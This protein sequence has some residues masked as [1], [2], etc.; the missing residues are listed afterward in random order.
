MK[1]SSNIL[2]LRFLIAMLLCLLNIQGG[3]VFSHPAAIKLAVSCNTPVSREAF[4]PTRSSDGGDFLQCEDDLS[5]PLVS[6]DS[7]DSGDGSCC[8][9][10]LEEG[11]AHVLSIDFLW[12]CIPPADCLFQPSPRTTPVPILLQTSVLR[13]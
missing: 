12:N 10:I 7:D 4:L 3:R 11:I 6:Q 2:V 9:D 5:S 8:E 1:H 13:I